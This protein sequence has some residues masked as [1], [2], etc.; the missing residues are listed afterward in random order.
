MLFLFACSCNKG[1]YVW[2]INV[3]GLNPC[4]NIDERDFVNKP[5]KTEADPYVNPSHLK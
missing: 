1:Q 3:M 2:N 5:E 4:S